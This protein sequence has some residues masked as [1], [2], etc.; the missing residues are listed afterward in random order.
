MKKQSEISGLTGEAL[1]RSLIMGI[2]IR[3]IPPDQFSEVLRQLSVIGNNINQIARVA[4]MTRTVD[5]DDIEAIKS[6]Q[7]KIWCGVKSL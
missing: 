1:I 7:A 2:E 6:L 4:N 3:P 5:K